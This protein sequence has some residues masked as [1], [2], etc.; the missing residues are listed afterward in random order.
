MKTK[1]ILFF[2]L[3]LDSF[4]L[5]Y[6]TSEL[7]ISYRETQI[8]EQT[9]LLS[10]LVNF[11]FDLFD[12]NDFA[13][14]IPMIFFHIL[15]VVLIYK[16]SEKYLKYER[17]R[18]WLS[19]IFILLPGVMSSAI[20]LSN[21]SLV[22][23]GLFLFVYIY[24]NYH[25]KYSYLV[26]FF[27]SF[28][29]QDFI[30]LFFALIFYSIYIKDKK[31]LI[32]NILFLFNSIF[33]YGFSIKGVPSSHF[34]DILGI[35]SAVFSPIVFIYIFYVLYRHYVT[36]ELDI[37]WFIS[38]TI[39][40]YTILLSFRQKIYIEHYAPYVILAL[41]LAAQSFAYAYRVR[42]KQF[43]L[44]YKYTFIVALVLLFIHSI[45]IFFNKE[46]YVFLDKP[47]KYFAYEMHIAKELANFLKQNNIDCIS[48]SKKMQPRLKFYG[49]DKCEQYSL[50]KH[51]FNISPILNV[52]ISYNKKVIYKRYVTKINNN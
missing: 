37:I 31:F 11:S 20:V 18:V 17:D 39:L 28:L 23:F 34:L 41:P 27:Y 15:S 46:L 33:I 52:K 50:H 25:I 42:L 49:I 19:L 2:L 40:I 47:K 3:L 12:R 8:L 13:L 26:L 35:Y 9:S 24:M 32:A 5:I 4:V 36:K 14:R 30:Y 38:S 21:A 10:Y 48:S 43:R 6:Q 1:L 44:K 16:I 45:V 22:I 51:N 29:L 7:S